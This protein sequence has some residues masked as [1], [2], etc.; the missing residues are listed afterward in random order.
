MSID[1]VANSKLHPSI[2][3]SREELVQV[4][5][6]GEEKLSSVLV[7]GTLL[8]DTCKRGHRG[9]VEVLTSS[10]AGLLIFFNSQYIY[11]CF[12]RS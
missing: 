11:V 7:T 1:D 6:Y 9:S 3:M 10:T 4:A 8:C 5:G 12:D 2:V